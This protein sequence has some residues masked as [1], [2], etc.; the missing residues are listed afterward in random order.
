MRTNLK[1][2]YSLRAQVALDL[3]ELD[4]LDEELTQDLNT[5]ARY[6]LDQPVKIR[7]KTE[8]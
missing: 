2:K 4:E 5:V 7:T 6:F 8:N 3:Q 1:L